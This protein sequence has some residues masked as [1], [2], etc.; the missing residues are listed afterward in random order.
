M[1][2]RIITAIALTITW[3]VPAGAETVR[4][5][6][7]TIELEPVIEGLDEP[8]GM[9]FLPD[10]RLMISERGGRLLLVDG[11]RSSVVEG[12][13]EVAARGQG[14]LLDVTVHPEFKT[15]RQVYLT[16]S[17]AG[18]DGVNSATTLSRAVLDGNRLTGLEQLFVQDRFSTPGRHYGSRLAWLPDG[19][20][21][22]SIG[23]RG[24]A[25]PRAQDI[26]DHAGSLL[27]LNADGTPAA[28][29]P[30]SGIS[31]ARPEIWSYGHRNIQGLLVHPETGTVWATEHGPRGG[32][33]LNQIVPGANYGWP[34]VSRGRDYRTEKRYFPYTRRSMA[35]VVDPEIDW[36]PGLHPSGLAVLTGDT[37]PNWRGNL[38]AG[39]LATEQIRRIV[40]EDGEVVHEERLIQGKAGRVRDLTVGPDGLVYFVTDN[41]EGNDGLLRIRPAD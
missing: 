22:M 18:P 21:L 26:A 33:E 13:P 27:R 31:G 15:N 29:N 9:E 12:T 34:I 20:L 19:T 39:G 37:F 36:T 32:D 24:A 1:R 14:G 28:G 38:L 30:F 17:Q 35:G 25:P 5:E 7:Q 41:G 6:Y 4:T 40:F 2:I 8:W 3:L 16:W 10:G 11:D 23:D